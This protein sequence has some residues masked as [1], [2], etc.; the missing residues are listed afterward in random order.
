MA[1]KYNYRPGTKAK[2]TTDN[3]KKY[4]RTTQQIIR[5]VEWLEVENRIPKLKITTTNGTKVE[6]SSADYGDRQ[7]SVMWEFLSEGDVVKIEHCGGRIQKVYV[8]VDQQYFSVLKNIVEKPEELLLT[9]ENATGN[10]RTAKIRQS[11]IENGKTLSQNEYGTVYDYDQTCKRWAEA[12]ERSEDVY[13]TIFGE[14][15]AMIAFE[16]PWWDD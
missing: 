7:W 10:R 12:V 5:K 6:I 13:V 2:V 14:R 15:V 9:L 8:E 4:M 16:A 1:K 3:Q 11:D